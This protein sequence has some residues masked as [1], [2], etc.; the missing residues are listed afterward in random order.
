MEAAGVEVDGNVEIAMGTSYTPSVPVLAAQAEHF[1]S[2][3]IGPVSASSAKRKVKSS[4]QDPQ[5]QVK[6]TP[7]SK[8]AHTS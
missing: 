5:P 1:D 3:K 4:N 2:P 8:V 7:P 6:D